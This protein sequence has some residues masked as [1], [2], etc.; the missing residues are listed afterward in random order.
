MFRTFMFLDFLAVI[1]GLEAFAW[2]PTKSGHLQRGP[3]GSF[4]NYPQH[5][6]TSLEKSS[7]DRTVGCGVRVCRNPGAMKRS[8]AERWL[9]FYLYI[10][11]HVFSYL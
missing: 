1:T 8:R 10:K 4:F 6:W 9:D 5:G 7:S 3:T 2:I 11:I